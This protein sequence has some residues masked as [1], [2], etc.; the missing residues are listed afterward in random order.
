M[1]AARKSRR[2]RTGKRIAWFL[3]TTH[4]MQWRRIGIR[5]R[6]LRMTHPIDE[7]SKEGKFERPCGAAAKRC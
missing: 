4:R 1:W 2:V 5:S 3:P 7:K 6:A